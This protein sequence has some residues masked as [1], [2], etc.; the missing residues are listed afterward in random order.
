MNSILVRLSIA[1]MLLASCRILTPP[2]AATATP[3][4]PQLSLSAL[5]NAEY[6][7]PDWGTF[8]LVQG[9]YQRPPLN[10]G[11]SSSAHMTQLL[12]AVAYGDLDADGTQDA[13]VFLV[14]QNGGTGH[15]VELAA[16]LNHNGQPVNVSTRSI[17]DRVGVEAARIQEGVIRLD[18]R[19]HGP[20]DGLCCPSQ[21]ETW[22]FKLDANQLVRLP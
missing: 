2:L 3:A 13:V 22:R 12:E 10:P 7:S 5:Q 6:T 11:E 16:M 4:A 17:G 9:V 15:F 1:S 14:T 20:N 21:F 8:R 18:L 19:V